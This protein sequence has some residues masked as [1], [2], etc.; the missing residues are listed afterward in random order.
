MNARAGLDLDEKEG[1][2]LLKE[3]GRGGEGDEGR[4][5][6]CTSCG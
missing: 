3:W 1:W 6:A 5:I 2:G 4:D